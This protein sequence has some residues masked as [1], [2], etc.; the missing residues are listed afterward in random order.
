MNI[1]IDAVSA[2]N[3]AQIALSTSQAD[4]TKFVESLASGTFS[5]LNPADEYVADKIS[6]DTMSRYA[7]V[8]NAQHGM[9]LTAAADSVLA[10]VGDS[11][12]RIKELS[13]K[14]ANDTYSDSQRQAIQAEIDELSAGISKTL[15]S[16]NYNGKSILNVVNADNPQ[17]AE[18]I[19]FQIGSGTTGDSV[20]S[21]DPNIKMP[22]DMSF[23]VSSAEN[24]RV[25][26]QLADEMMSDLTAKRS[27]IASVQTGLINSV[28]NNMTAIVNN[29]SAYSQIADTDYASAMIDL[30]K[31]KLS[32]ETLITVLKANFQ[33]Q[34]NVLDLI[35]GIA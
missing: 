23:D 12:S 28:E 1:N 6:T 10:D 26:A 11:V 3:I 13:L 22:D 20:I 19:N 16:V 15:Q 32:Q 25:S 17:K 29:Q 4:F 34:S 21:Y 5:E 2:V 30:V 31:S 8:E 7:A 14:A 24:A 18:N 27:E 33:T 9:N 35:S